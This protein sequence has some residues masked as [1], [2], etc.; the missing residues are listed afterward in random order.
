M[1]EL[2]AVTNPHTGAVSYVHQ[3]IADHITWWPDDNEQF[4]AML[5]GVE[6]FEKSL[7]A[8]LR[9]PAN[10]VKAS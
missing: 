2:V 8:S 1:Y 5:P 3:W 6:A 4:R 9:Q 10:G 7:V